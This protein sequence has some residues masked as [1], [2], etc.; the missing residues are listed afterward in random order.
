MDL[1]VIYLFQF[2]EGD[3]ELKVI[4]VTDFSDSKRYLDIGA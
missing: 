1:E 2:G 3:F 4:S